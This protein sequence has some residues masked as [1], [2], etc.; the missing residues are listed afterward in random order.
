MPALISARPL[1]LSS[2]PAATPRKLH[3]PGSSSAGFLSGSAKESLWL[4]TGSGEVRSTPLSDCDLSLWLLMWPHLCCGLS[5]PRC[6]LH[7]SSSSLGQ[8]L[9]YIPSLYP[10]PPD[11]R[12]VPFP[13]TSSE[14]GAGSCNRQSL[15]CF[16]I[17][18]FSSTSTSVTGSA[19]CFLY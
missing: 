19:Y 12:L 16:P 13:C 1:L 14:A 10:I 8:P 9:P 17:S 5:F 11:P 7:S 2:I 15:G 4:E 3:F 18:C 6:P